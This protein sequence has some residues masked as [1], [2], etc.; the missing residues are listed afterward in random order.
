MLT[1]LVTWPLAGFGELG[2]TPFE[3]WEIRFAQIWEPA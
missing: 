2:N 3:P 1:T